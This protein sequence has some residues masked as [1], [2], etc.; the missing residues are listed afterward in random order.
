MGIVVQLGRELQLACDET[1]ELRRA[2][3][4]HA[5][6]RRLTQEDGPLA[7]LLMEQQGSFAGGNPK[8]M[9]MH[10][11][12]DDDT[13][14]SQIHMQALLGIREFS[15]MHQSLHLGVPLHR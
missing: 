4:S 2:L 3:E 12:T 7:K 13:L 8:T 1:V 10:G 15:Q 9:S 5:S 6:W 11:M 14:A